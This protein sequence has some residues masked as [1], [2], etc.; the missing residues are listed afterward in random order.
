MKLLADSCDVRVEEQFQSVPGGGA[1]VMCRKP[2]YSFGSSTRGCSCSS[3][4]ILLVLAGRDIAEVLRMFFLALATSE[5]DR[6]QA[7]EI[8]EGNTVGAESFR[9]LAYWS[10]QF[11]LATDLSMGKVVRFRTRVRHRGATLLRKLGSRRRLTSV[12]FF[13]GVGWFSTTWYAV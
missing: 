12:P 5:R 8:P 7:N 11:S 9:L 3:T 4:V 6:G 1:V 13:L 2:C 10:G